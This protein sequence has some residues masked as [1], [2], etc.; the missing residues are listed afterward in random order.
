VNAPRLPRAIA[1]AVLLVARSVTSAAGWATLHG[2]ALRV[3]TTE[4]DLVAVNRPATLAVASVTW[5]VTAL[6]VRSA[7][8]VSYPLLRYV[9]GECVAV[10]LFFYLFIIVS[11]FGFE[12]DHAFSG[13]EVG[14]VS[15][16]CPTE[17]KGE[18]VCYNCKQPGHVQAACPN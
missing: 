18:R 15:R 16:D 1:T 9:T 13:G 10:P 17:A 5:L 2:T 3:A 6:K 7:T 4:V 11:F 14:H 8:T 12:I